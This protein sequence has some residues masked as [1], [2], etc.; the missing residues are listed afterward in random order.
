MS[1][2]NRKKLYEEVWKEPV[3]VVAKRY[4]ISDTALAK[5][6]RRL[7]VPLPPRGYWAK[8]RAGVSASIP[9]LPENMPDRDEAKSTEEKH[10]S[11]NAEK[12]PQSTKKEI[13]H[14]E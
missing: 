2:Y 11:Q 10:K 12:D 14:S 5:A 9:A 4:G 7:T 13:Y 3:S 8:V 6:C 1:R